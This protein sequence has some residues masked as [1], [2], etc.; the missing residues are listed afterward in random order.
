MNRLTE[1]IRRLNSLLL[2]K[3][4]EEAKIETLKSFLLAYMREDACNDIGFDATIQKLIDLGVDLDFIDEGRN[5]SM[6]S[7]E[8]AQN[9]RDEICLKKLEAGLEKQEVSNNNQE[10]GKRKRSSRS[11]KSKKSKKTRKSKKTKKAKKTRKH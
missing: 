3:E 11:S 8:L 6:T 5:D 2:K 10:G 7:L 1:E 9:H 4:G